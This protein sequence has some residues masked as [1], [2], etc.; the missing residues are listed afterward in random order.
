MGIDKRTNYL[1]KGL[2]A[3]LKFPTDQDIGHEIEQ[4]RRALIHTQN[5]REKV[6]ENDF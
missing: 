6:R 4:T 5:K 3:F 1:E 2:K